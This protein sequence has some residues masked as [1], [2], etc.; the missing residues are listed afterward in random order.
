MIPWES[1]LSVAHRNMTSVLLYH[2]FTNYLRTPHFMLK[3]IFEHNVLKWNVSQEIRFAYKSYTLYFISVWQSKISYINK[4][5]QTTN[6][7]KVFQHI[8]RIIFET[9]KSSK[10]TPNAGLSNQS[11]ANK[12]GKKQWKNCN[13]FTLTVI[14]T[15]SQKMSIRNVQ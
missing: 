2:C 11:T 8:I 14:Q 5:Y 7:Q 15:F 4:G 6:I 13:H 12:L 10:N 3:I 1:T 9:K